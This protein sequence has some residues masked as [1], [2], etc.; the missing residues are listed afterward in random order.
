MKDAN[1]T[2][3]AHN[4]LNIYRFFIDFSM[5][6]QKYLFLLTF[7]SFNKLK[8]FSL[9]LSLLNWKVKSIASYELCICW[10]FLAF[11]SQYIDIHMLYSFSN[12][13][14]MISSLQHIVSVTSVW[15]VLNNSMQLIMAK[16]FCNLVT[17]HKTE[18]YWV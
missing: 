8:K 12:A 14:N 3:T 11:F 1:R 4:R 9:S 13:E 10:C 2:E 5:M 18:N 15:T 7:V 6:I 16:T 17:H